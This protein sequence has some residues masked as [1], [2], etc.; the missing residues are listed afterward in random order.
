MKVVMIGADRSVKGGVSAVV[1]NLYQAGLEKRVDL[2]YIGTMVD[3][4]K[5]QKACQA[6]K[7]LIRFL[8]AMPGTDLVHVNMAADASCFR[9]MI[10][11]KAACLFHKKILIHEHG[12]DFQGFYYERC[13]EKQRRR[14]KKALNR[15]DL[16]LVLSDTWKEFFAELVDP[17]KI[18]VLENAVP[19][20]KQGKKDYSAHRAVFLGRLCREKGI[21]ELLDSVPLIRRQIPDFQLVLCGFWEA[22]NEELRKKA[23]ELDGAVICPGWVS[24]KEREQLFESCSI[25]V[26]PTWFEGQP[27]SLLEAMAA[28]MC[29]A[30]SA[31]GGIPQILAGKKEIA[32]DALPEGWEGCGILFPA[33]RTQELAAVMIRLLKEE[34]LRRGL[35]ERARARVLKQYDMER[36][37]D[38]LVEF[39]EAVLSR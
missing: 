3:G 15:A 11:M 31:V 12:G 23:Q 36:Y 37:V 27:V 7:A 33:Q 24:A 8:F 38:R 25:F 35:G 21:G 5:A 20:P 19:V 18:H 10:F 32:A 29:V 6:L 22:G 34:E 17:D 1:N 16:F 4:S 9:K 14:I 13:R 28:G 2:T 26:L 30:A 39:Y